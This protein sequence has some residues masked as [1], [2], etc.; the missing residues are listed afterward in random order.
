[1]ER[2]QL[3]GKVIPIAGHLKE[4]VYMGERNQGKLHR[5]GDP[6][7]GPWRKNRMFQGKDLLGRENTSNKGMEPRNTDGSWD[8]MVERSARL[9][10]RV[11]E[12]M[13]VNHTCVHQ[14]PSPGFWGFWIIQAD[15][16][17]LIWFGVFVCLFVCLFVFLPVPSAAKFPMPGIEPMS[18]TVAWATAVSMLDP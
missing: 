16:I 18:I 9:S 17:L 15:K 1:M 3:H 5:G 10:S 8:Y 11:K 14:N 4:E 6:E 7:N 12:N 13:R 2:D